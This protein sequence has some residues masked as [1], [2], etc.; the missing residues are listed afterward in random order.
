MSA[1]LGVLAAA[2]GLLACLLSAGGD[3]PKPAPAK[4]AAVCKA[5]TAITIDGVLDEPA[6]KEAGTIEA[7]Y[8]WGKVGEKSKQ[9][10]MKAWYTWDDDYLYIGY[11][12]FDTNLT[13]RG[14]G[15]KK[16]PPGNMTE[17][18]EIVHPSEPVD[19]VEFFISFGD[20]QMFWEV[21]HNALNHFNDIFITVVDP[22]RPIAKS[23]LFFD[24]IHFGTS[25]VLE[26]DAE[27]GC[28]R[29][30]AVKLKPK[31]DG[32]PST[33]NTPGD[34]DTG[35]V[36]EIR[37]PWYGL[38]APRERMTAKEVAVAGQKKQV[39]GPWKMAGQEMMILAVTQDGDLKEHYHHSSP[40]KPGSWFHKGT[41]H[42]PRY[43]LTEKKPGS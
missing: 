22:S 34:I 28:T 19:V 27:S 26:D 42:W 39:R 18:A 16:G 35:Y 7:D 29:R 31:T 14:S 40:T 12:T 10:R 20:P 5:R 37:L 1:R 6:W 4:P 25:E 11:E 36:G 41:E 13:A 33:V 30:M 15:K 32:K 38:G 3:E 2:A 9:P 17:V 24:G 8:V 23:R 21:H 43:V